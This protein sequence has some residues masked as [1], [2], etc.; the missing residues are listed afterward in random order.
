MISCFGKC[1]LGLKAQA[2][3]ICSMSSSTWSQ[4]WTIQ[5]RSR[6]SVQVYPVLSSVCIHLRLESS[7]RHHWC[8]FFTGRQSTWSQ[9]QS[10][11]LLALWFTSVTNVFM[12]RQVPF[13][14]ES[15]GRPLVN[16]LRVWVVQLKSST[17][18]IASRVLVDKCNQCFHA[19]A[20]TWSQVQSRSLLVF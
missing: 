15:S 11:L 10:G 20:T 6:Y 4:V 14:S 5:L 3:R 19:S 1:P 12:L 17:I 18:K 8:I 2:R 9:V 7:G 16:I 13:W